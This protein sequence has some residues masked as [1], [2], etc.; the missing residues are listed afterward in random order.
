MGG[1]LV[2][3]ADDLGVAR[4]ATLGI[5]R[6]H[7]EGVV[8]SASLTATAPDYEHAIRTCV[9]ACPR[10]GVGLHFTLSAG[11]P[12]SPPG[13]VPL[14][15]GGDGFLRWRFGSLQRALWRREPRGLLDQIEVELEAQLDR[16]AADG[17]APDHVDSE[18]HVHLIPG[19][20]ERVV[21]AAERRGIGFIRMGGD[22]GGRYLRIG[23]LPTLL[24]AGGFAKRWLFSRL[25]ARNRRRAAR[26]RT[27][28][29]FASYLY[30]GRLDLVIADLVRHPPPEAV[31]EVMVHPGIPE[32]SRGV[33]LGNPSLERYVAS[34][35]R[36]RELEACLRARELAVDGRL[37]SFRQLS[38]VENVDAR[39]EKA[40]TGR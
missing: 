39:G 17:V 37:V 3:N 15:V 2:V 38:E 11:R 18:R 1:L 33:V 23:H 16:L 8:T 25:T 24:R 30:S 34:E 19:I 5:L 9:R 7:R 40:G 14:L 31:T 4:G 27:A 21:A 20:F 35:D 12:V 29:G 6:A 36:R 32:E 10:L 26:L 22:V 13:R 28:D